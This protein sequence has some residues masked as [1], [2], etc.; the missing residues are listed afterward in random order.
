MRFRRIPS[1]KMS[2]VII[3]NIMLSQKDLTELANFFFCELQEQILKLY[4]PYYSAIKCNKLP[5]CA[6]IWTTLKI[7]LLSEG[8][9]AQKRTFHMILFDWAF[10]LWWQKADQWL[11][12]MGIPRGDLQKGHE[13]T[14]GGNGYVHSLDCSVMVS[15][16]YTCVNTWEICVL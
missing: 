8:N 7:I 14:F 6:T 9:Q 12:G 13:E 1:T 11:L 5:I 3:F 15:R 10:C 4:I 2:S 16:V